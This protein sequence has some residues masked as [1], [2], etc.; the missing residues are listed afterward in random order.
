MLSENTETSEITYMDMKIANINLPYDYYDCKFLGRSY[1]YMT[2][3]NDLYE[4]MHDSI[5]S[6]FGD[7]TISDY[8]YKKLP[9]ELSK[10]LVV[11][12]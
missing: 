9:E 10:L 6:L 12:A 5:D 8:K 11:K 2:L 3:Y 1:K 7:C 4:I